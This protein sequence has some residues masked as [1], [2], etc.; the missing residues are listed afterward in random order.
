MSEA[1]APPCT[2]GKQG[3]SR[4]AGGGAEAL[5]GRGGGGNTVGGG[6]DAAE[7]RDRG[8]V[9]CEAVQADSKRAGGFFALVAVPQ[10]VW[11]RFPGFRP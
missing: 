1:T 5:L 6:A 11:T 9:S 2:A 8:G 4:R 10:A 3:A 7:R